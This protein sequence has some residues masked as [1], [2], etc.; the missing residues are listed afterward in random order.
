MQLEAQMHK[1]INI[2]TRLKK[3][4]AKTIS[5][6][7]FANEMTNKVQNINWWWHTNLSRGL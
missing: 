2:L 7:I 1:G 4:L 6:H 5:A 3:Y